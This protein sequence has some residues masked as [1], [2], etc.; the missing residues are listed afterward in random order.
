LNH[1][2]ERKSAFDQDDEPNEPGQDKTKHFIN[3]FGYNL[4]VNLKF[5]FLG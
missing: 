5:F 3:P 4:E 2:Y 1:P